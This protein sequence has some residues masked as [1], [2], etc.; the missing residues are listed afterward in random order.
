M[1]E[2]CLKDIRG[3]QINVGD[4]VAYP[5]RTGSALWMSY[6]KVDSIYTDG[7]DWQDNPVYRVKVQKHPSNKIVTVY[8]TERIVK[9]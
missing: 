2:A 4:T 9:L 6:G 8:C 1:N 5:V 3:I 7:T